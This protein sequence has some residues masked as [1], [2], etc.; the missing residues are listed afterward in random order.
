MQPSFKFAFHEVEAIQMMIKSDTIRLGSV[1]AEHKNQSFEKMCFKIGVFWFALVEEEQAKER[2]LRGFGERPGNEKQTSSQHEILLSPGPE[3][4]LPVPPPSPNPEAQ[5]S[6]E[7]DICREL[8]KTEVNRPGSEKSR[9]YIP[10]S[11]IHALLLSFQQFQNSSDDSSNS[12]TTSENDSEA[13]SDSEALPI[14]GNQL[15]VSTSSTSTPIHSTS[16]ETLKAQSSPNSPTVLNSTT[17]STTLVGSLDSQ[18]SSPGACPVMKDAPEEIPRAAKT[19]KSE[20]K[21]SIVGR[22]GDSPFRHTSQATVTFQT[23]SHPSSTTTSVSSSAPSMSFILPPRANPSKC[24]NRYTGSTSGNQLSTTHSASNYLR[25]RSASSKRGSSDAESI[26]YATPSS[27]TTP[28]SSFQTESTGLSTP[29]SSF[30][31]P[32]STQMSSK[33]GVV[34]TSSRTSSRRSS[35]ASAASAFAVATAASR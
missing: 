6:R 3:L 12:T 1:Q 31:L 15:I 30:Q 14:N 19:E 5:I 4:T 32:E 13:Q 8:E 24:T 10:A 7:E 2:Y 28:R 18:V 21:S 23:T 9:F 27:T 33:A 29:R 16:S 22:S 25:V 34:V 17:S 20:L 11:E 26:S 35:T